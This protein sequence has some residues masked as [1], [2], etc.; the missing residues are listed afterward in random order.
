MRDSRYSDKSRSYSHQAEVTF[1]RSRSILK[2]CHGGPLGGAVE[3]HLPPLL[4]EVRSP[5]GALFFEAVADVD[6][7]DG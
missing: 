4:P 5:A 1:L 3:A 7:E 6:V 2:D